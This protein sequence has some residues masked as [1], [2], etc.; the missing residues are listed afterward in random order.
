VNYV[1][2]SFE[3]SGF[4]LS[5]IE[6][7][8]RQENHLLLGRRHAM[9]KGAV[10]EMRPK[11]VEAAL[12]AHSDLL[13]LLGLIDT[14]SV[15]HLSDCA[16]PLFELRHRSDTYSAESVR[17]GYVRDDRDEIFLALTTRLDSYR[18][19]HIQ[20]RMHFSLT[21]SDVAWLTRQT[22]ISLM[23]AANDP[24]WMIVPK[25]SMVYYATSMN[26][27]EFNT[28]KRTTLATLSR[29]QCH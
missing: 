14:G 5:P 18:Q 13:R 19:D 24:G 23:R 3:D 20:A 8:V 4:S 9:A 29:Q 28:A 1:S 2:Q 15:K 12:P 16:T 22:P 27:K 11:D 6:Q 10:H 26:H 25:V 17:D 7:G 21:T